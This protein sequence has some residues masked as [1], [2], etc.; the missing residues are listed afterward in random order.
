MIQTHI[1]LLLNHVAILGAIFSFILLLAGSVFGQVVLRKSAL[2]GLVFSAIVA[3]PV[4]L[5]GEPAEEAVEHLPGVTESAIHEHE[6]AGEAAIWVIGVTG[7]VSAITL[8]LGIGPAGKGR[9]LLVL[10][11]LLAVMSSV[12]LARTGWLGGKIRHSEIS[13]A[14]PAN[15]AGEQDDD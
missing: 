6:E 14:A 8:F 15:V 1:H 7:I 3:V 2:F 9:R 10:V 5:T 4:F 12:S 13:S 11:Y